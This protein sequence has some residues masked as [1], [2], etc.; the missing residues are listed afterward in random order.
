MET[1]SI[2]VKELKVNMLNLPGQQKEEEKENNKI[3]M[4][5]IIQ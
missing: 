4:T 3:T 5:Q 1:L 2:D